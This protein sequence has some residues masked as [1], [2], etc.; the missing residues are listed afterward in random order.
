MADYGLNSGIGR[1]GKVLRR[2][3]GMSDKDWRATPQVLAAV[4]RRKP[5]DL[6]N[7]LDA[8]RLAF[9]KFLKSLKTWPHV[10]AGWGRRVA[11]KD[12]ER[13]K[14]LRANVNL[15]SDFRVIWGVQ[16]PSQ[17]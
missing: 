7:A 16:S 4:A 2:L 8:E 1:A 10:G 14:P 17:K 6:I 5:A 11:P 13:A 9:L 3:L 12:D 15:R